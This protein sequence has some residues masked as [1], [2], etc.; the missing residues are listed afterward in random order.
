V[1]QS[2]AYAVV[3]PALM[4]STVGIIQAGVWIHGRHVTAEAAYA[5][6]DVS[7]SAGSG[8]ESAVAAA[9][10]VAA[11]GG[12]RDVAISVSRGPA[13]VTVTVRATV[14]MFFELPLATVT[15]S[16]TAPVERVTAP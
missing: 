13:E 3:V 4:L 14:P 16:A 2:V 12:L 1:S 11:V 5:A 15:E 10:R 8:S 6:A 9:R 7:R